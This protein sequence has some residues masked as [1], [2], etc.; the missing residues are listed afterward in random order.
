MRRGIMQK[1]L[2]AA[3]TCALMVPTPAG[4]TAYAADTPEEQLPTL[5]VGRSATPD[6]SELSI[7]SFKAGQ[8]EGS[9][10]Q[11]GGIVRD[12]AVASGAYYDQLST[13][14]KKFY[15]GMVSMSKMKPIGQYENPNLNSS[16]VISTL[17]SQR[18][19]LIIKTGASSERELAEAFG[20][21]WFAYQYD[22]PFEY[23]IPLCTNY[24]YQYRNKSGKLDV[25]YMIKE[26]GSYDYDSMSKSAMAAR[27]KAVSEIRSAGYT[28]DAVRE[29]LTY[30]YICENVAYNTP[31]TRGSDESQMYHIAHT[32]YASLV[33]KNAVCDGYAQGCA[34]IL[35]AMGVETYVLGSDD[36]AWNLIGLDGD[37]YEFDTCWGD[38]GATSDYS[39]FNLTTSDM[40]SMDRTGYHRR[41]SYNLRLPTANGTTYTYSVVAGMMNGQTV[42][43]DKPIQQEET[44]PLTPALPGNVVYATG[45]AILSG[46]QYTMKSDGTAVYEA[47]SSSGAT[48]VTIPD[49]VS[50]NGSTYKVTAIAAGACLKN[51]NL[52]K[53]VIG[54]N[55]AEI[56]AEAFYKCKSLKTVKLA[57]GAALTS[58]GSNAFAKTRSDIKFKITS[59]T[60]EGFSNAVKLLS[61]AGASGAKFKRK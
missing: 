18:R 54:Q 15:L 9:A 47:S 55:V 39:Y 25:Y 10:L 60:S 42:T 40:R 6:V 51:K 20:E 21:A 22:H 16:M 56:G 46:G 57:N 8:L 13:V 44:T 29:L 37:Y 7:S 33:L 11:L 43:D 41:N 26:R 52:T 24:V 5:T 23:M 50:C 61:A 35:N 36:H 48:R 59:T 19:C 31:A 32:S 34:T 38:D 53:L 1:L 12:S 17:I 4:G 28:Q 30:D 27:D 49:T 3:L 14:G 58:V 45:T 2:A